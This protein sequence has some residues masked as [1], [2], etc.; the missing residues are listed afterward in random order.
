MDYREVGKF[1]NQNAENWTALVRMGADVYRD[2][3]NTP[4]FLSIMPPVTGLR[5]LD[6]G[7]GE[8]YNT[9]LLAA[10]G[11]AISAIDIADVFIRHA[12]THPDQATR[13]IGYQL[14]SATHLP[15]NENSFEFATAFMSLMDVPDQHL[16]VAEAFR[17]LKPGGW[18]QFSITHPCYFTAK[19]EW[20]LDE[21][22][23]RRAYGCSDYFIPS[24][25]EIEEWIFSG[26]PKELRESLP[27]FRI[28][29]FTRTLSS[30]LNL[31]L[32]TGFLLEK[33][34]EPTADDKTIERWPHVADTRIVPYFLIIRCRKPNEADQQRDHDY[35]RDRTGRP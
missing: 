19:W 27:K 30:W 32:G 7:C 5:G 21:N 22:G 2:Q 33:F 34:V 10:M 28:P 31:L 9:R 20:I 3:I 4:A 24:D 11:A 26:A 14:A 23:K 12:S 15:H 25:G 29:R 6:I 16:A 8:G 13:P 18:F 1:W 17:V 35:P